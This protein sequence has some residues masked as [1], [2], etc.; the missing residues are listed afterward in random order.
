MAFSRRNF[1]GLAGAA[2]VN[3]NPAS[4]STP[5]VDTYR[6]AVAAMGKITGHHFDSFIGPFVKHYTNYGSRDVKYSYVFKN[7]SIL[8]EAKAAL[9]YPEVAADFRKRFSEYRL[10]AGCDNSDRLDTIELL[11]G[12][13][14]RLLAETRMNLVEKHD[15]VKFPDTCVRNL[16]KK[17]DVRW[18]EAI[19]DVEDE[20]DSEKDSSFADES[21]REYGDWEEESSIVVYGKLEIVVEEVLGS[22]FAFVLLK[23]RFQLTK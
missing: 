19:E 5:S 7:N 22:D 4:A 2:A 18:D 10:V 1:F 14:T 6:R 11:Y 16:A 8:Q 23:P 21:E 20:T 12:K 17:E 13:E 9:Q 15:G 3:I